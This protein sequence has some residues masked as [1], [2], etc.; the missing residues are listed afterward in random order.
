MDAIGNELEANGSSW[1]QDQEQWAQNVKGYN[2][3]G[4]PKP[5]SMSE[6]APILIQLK[7]WRENKSGGEHSHKHGTLQGSEEWKTEE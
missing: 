6:A 7:Q 4:L 2:I 3:R 1:M 5:G